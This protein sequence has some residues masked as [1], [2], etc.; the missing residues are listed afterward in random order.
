MEPAKPESSTVATDVEL[1]TGGDGDHEKPR[2]EIKDDVEDESREPDLTD[3]EKVVLATEWGLPSEPS[4][5]W[6]TLYGDSSINAKQYGEIRLSLGF[7]P[8]PSEEVQKT[9]QAMMTDARVTSDIPTGILHI[10]V[11]QCQNLATNAKSGSPFVILESHNSVCIDRKEDNYYAWIDGP[12][13][14][15]THH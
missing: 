13:S 9:Y 11:H 10:T 5:I 7:Y 15:R 2:E 4:N 12:T 3:Q 6:K 8:V 14:N 1:G